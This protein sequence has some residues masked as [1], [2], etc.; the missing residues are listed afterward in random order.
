MK[1]EQLVMSLNTVG[2]RLK[3]MRM[4]RRLTQREMAKILEVSHSQYQK[5]ESNDNALSVKG[6]KRLN[7]VLEIS[8]D[9]LVTGKDLNENRNNNMVDIRHNTQIDTKIEEGCLIITTTVPL[10]KYVG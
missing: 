9:F 8:I 3:F 4:S 7:D 2:A 6:L 10:F 5:Y 1:K